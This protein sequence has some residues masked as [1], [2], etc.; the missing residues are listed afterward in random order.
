MTTW[1]DKSDSRG[2]FY[3][4]GDTNLTAVESLSSLVDFLR[5][6]ALGDGNAKAF[7]LLLF[8]VNSDT[9]RL[10]VALTT[11][12]K[13]M[14][15]KSDGC[16]LRVQEIQDFWYDLFE[17]EPP[18][19]E[20]TLRITDYVRNLGMTFRSELLSHIQELLRS[21]SPTG[22]RFIVFGSDPGKSVYDEYFA[23]DGK[24]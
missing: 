19:D 7:D 4:G 3:D 20:F 5:R 17:S 23:K 10:I 15:G 13:R 2:R 16:S 6:R 12:E 21:S 14:Q 9:G 18:D 11:M 22:F 24:I 8:E 1:I